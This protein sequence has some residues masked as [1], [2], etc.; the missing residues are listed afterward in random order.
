MRQAT[1]E[2]KAAAKEK[3][4]KFRSLAAKL[5]KMSEAERNVLAARLPG[6]VNCEGH[7]LSLHNVMLL[8]MQGLTTATMVGGF[9]QWKRQGRSVCKDQHGYMIFVPSSKR[10][11][12]NGSVEGVVGGLGTSSAFDEKGELFFFTGTVFDVSQTEE[13]NHKPEATQ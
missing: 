9:R 3:R 13:T 2:Q 5:G 1:Q 8:V 11:R 10:E 6:L 7:V 4:S 12:N